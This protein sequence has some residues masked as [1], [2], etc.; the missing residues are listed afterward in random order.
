MK[1]IC[2]RCGAYSPLN[3]IGS[4]MVCRICAPA[5]LEDIEKIRAAG[6]PVN[7]IQI[8]R[9]HFKENY[10]GIKYTCREVPREIETAWK[11]RAIKDGCNQRDILLAALAEYLK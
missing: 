5:L 1:K 7:A 4:A 9:K 3:Q 8:A 2:D 11:E 6:K 10:A